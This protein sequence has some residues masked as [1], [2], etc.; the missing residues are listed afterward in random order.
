[1]V[2]LL[3]QQ[4]EFGTWCTT[5]GNIRLDDVI[6]SSFHEAFKNR[7]KKTASV[8]LSGTVP[9]FNALQFT[10]DIAITRDQAVFEVYYQRSGAYS[11]R[12]AN[13][14]VILRDL[15][16]ASGNA[17]ISVYNPSANVLRIEIFVS[18]NTGAPA[19]LSS[20]TYDFTIYVFDTPFSA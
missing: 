2:A 19:A 10:T 3:A 5:M 9:A 20:Q 11:R 1:M 4:R 14:S 16:W 13:N 17:N 18:N 15:T 7:E 8:V 12:I 6:L